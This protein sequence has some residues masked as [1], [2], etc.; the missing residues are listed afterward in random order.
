MLTGDLIRVRVQKGELA[1]S[2][3]DPVAPKVVERAEE[4]LTLFR[5]GVGRRRVD[6]DEEIDT[7]VGDGTDHKLV[8][9][10]VKVL[11][12]K[13]TFD[14]SAPIPPAEIRAKVFRLATLRGPLSPLE[15]EGGRP[16]AAAIYREVAAELGVDPAVLEGALYADHADQQ[17][18]VSVDV[19]SARWL[20]DRYNVALV[21]SV[22]LK[23]HELRVRL[24]HAEPARARQLLRAVKFHQLICDVQPHADG[25]EIVL[26]GP[27]SLFSQT[28][29]YGMSLAK[30]F[31][32]LL[33][34]GGNW[35]ATA[36]V[37]WRGK[38]TMK[39]TPAM[40]LRSHYRD[41]GAYETRESLW[42][43]ER[44]LALDSGWTLD[45]EVTPIDQGGEGVVVPDFRFTKGKK[46]AWLEILGFWRKGSIERRLKLLKRH[47]PANLIVAVSKKLAGEAGEL[48]DLVVPFVEVI[49][50][51][52]VLR[53]VEA[54]AR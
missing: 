25:Y 53:R 29:R 41:T 21:Q 9:G 35:E 14:V 49:P 23:A 2:F 27:A 4:I 30:F 43:E 42:F 51:K 13:S 19:P 12:D 32:A 18:L 8:K 7:L 16:T 28:T 40:G 39:L 37:D 36:K 3:V 26:D 52:E 31:P 1:P 47:G 17:V 48:P 44:F 45:R 15:I 20:L 33:L 10:L 46:V 5:E 54:V 6:L 38:K 34:Q 50:A 24:T 22:L 11:T